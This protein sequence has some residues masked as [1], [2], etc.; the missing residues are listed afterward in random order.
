VLLVEHLDASLDQDRASWSL[1]P[2]LVPLLQWRQDHVPYVLAL[3]DRGGADLVAEA[4]GRRTIDRTSGEGDPERKSAPGGWSQKRYQ[5]R[6]DEDWAAT[7]RL[8][9]EEVT[10]LADRVDARTVV[11]GGDVRAVHLVLDAV[12]DRLAERAHVI[13]HGRAT[14]GSEDV[15]QSE[16]RRL[17]ATAVAEDSVALLQ[18]FREE[19]GQLDRAVDGPAATIDALNRAAVEVLFVHDAPD[20]HAWVTVDS[21]VPIGLDAA[22]A[23]VGTDAQAF[24]VPLA[25]ALVR[26]AAGTGARVRVVPAHG[27]VDSGIGALLRWGDPGA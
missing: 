1:L 6:A 10:R 2:D 24:E 9:A 14:D 23:T 21:A 25:D 13:D 26:A 27:P 16:V 18:K 22:M 17:V 12:P 4:P 3:C 7:A 19:R 5:Q 20:A 11:V 15:R 8:V